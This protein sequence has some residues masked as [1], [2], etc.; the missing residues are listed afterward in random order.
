MSSGSTS[1][2]LSY[3][4]SEPEPSTSTSLPRSAT[5]REL[6]KNRLYVG[7]LHPTVDECALISLSLHLESTRRCLIGSFLPQ[8][9]PH[10][11]LLQIRETLASRLPLSQDRC[12]ARQAPRLRLCGVR[13][14]FGK[15]TSTVF[16]LS[17][18]PEREKEKCVLTPGLSLFPNL[19]PL[20]LPGSA[21]HPLLL[22]VSHP[23]QTRGGCSLAARINVID[24][25]TEGGGRLS[26]IDH[27]LNHGIRFV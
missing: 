21:P 19:L 1:S 6:L 18:R 3:P 11:G 8:I 9:H 24:C 14:R 10:P 16:T 23:A 17:R 25:K 7:N 15:F 20:R 27:I 5:P 12:T 4:V 22:I 26:D 13:E 2:L